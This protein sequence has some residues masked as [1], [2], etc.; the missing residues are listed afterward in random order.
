MLDWGEDSWVTV[1]ENHISF[2]FDL[3]KVMFCSGNNTERMRMGSLRIPSEVV[4]DLFCGIGYY[5]VPLLVHASAR[6][7]HACEINPHS[8]AA[9]RRN[10]L[11]HDVADRCVIHEGDNRLTT[12]GLQGVASRVLCGL[13][14]SSKGGWAVAVYVLSK[15]GGVIHI[16]ENV[17][18]KEIASFAEEA[19][20]E[21]E[22][23][24]RDA[25]KEMQVRVGHVERVKSYAPRVLHVVVD[26]Y[27]VPV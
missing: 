8:V 15:D 10:L 2:S 7:V 27:C 12:H 4:V 6:R 11:A 25:G 5:T 14:P 20:S 9:L 16:H 24:S 22:R 1:K 19:R 18:E 21:I 17:H 13:L 23:L 3:C 26:L